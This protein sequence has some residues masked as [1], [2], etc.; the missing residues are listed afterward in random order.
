[1]VE[2]RVYKAKWKEDEETF[3]SDKGSFVC[4]M[5]ILYY[6]L[7]FFFKDYTNTLFF[8]Q[9]SGIS[10]TREKEFIKY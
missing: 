7:S 3:N 2:L 8:H 10:L 5:S 1:M 6:L 4:G 9:I